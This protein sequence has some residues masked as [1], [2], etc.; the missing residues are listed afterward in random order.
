MKI[1]KLMITLCIFLAT[2]LVAG[3]A[4]AKDPSAFD[5]VSSDSTLVTPKLTVTID[6]TKVTL[7]WNEVTG[8][9]NY[10]VHYAQYPYDNP[11]TIK[12]ID[13]GDKTSASY[14][15]LPGKAYHVAVKA[16][17]ASGFYCSDYSNIH[18]VIIPLVSTY[19]NSLGQE[20]KL[21]PAGTFTMG[22]PSGEPGRWIS[23]GPQHQVTLTQP[24]Y[25]QT[26]EVTQ[27]QWEA[28]M[29][30]NPSG[31]CPACPV[32]SVSWD[33][34]QTYI[35][36]MNL[37]GEGTYSLPTEAQWEY[38]ARA[39][40]TTAFYSGNI[41]KSEGEDPNL[42]AIGWYNWNSSIKAHP[43]AQKTANA[44]ELYDMSGNAS[45][46]CQD[47]YGSYASSAVSD[48][49][50]PS[51][52]SHRVLRGGSWD[53]PAKYC[54]SAFRFSRGPGFRGYGFRLLRQP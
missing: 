49:T 35:T 32:E 20:F 5:S 47:R 8:A 37:R 26:T 7:S 42:D 9:T 21:I 3:I 25:M 2:L 46:W 6:G 41:T 27:A 14:E 43:V 53:D 23:E 17:D 16:C 18:D 29:G 13:V 30:W 34:V 45:E 19:K 1:T 36:K 50:G 54:R 28:V 4:L 10:V 33:D 24:F 11:A 12:T 22:S 39:G 31:E 38:A 40:S 44:W 15:L 52:G 51:S 48:P